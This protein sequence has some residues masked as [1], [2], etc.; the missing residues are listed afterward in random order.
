MGGGQQQFIG[1]KLPGE[2]PF[3]QWCG[4]DRVS[5]STKVKLMFWN[6][7]FVPFISRNALRRIDENAI[8]RQL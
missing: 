5:G 7:P 8:F 6:V 1:R 4:N 3:L 2:I